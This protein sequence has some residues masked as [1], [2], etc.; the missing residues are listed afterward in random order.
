[1]RSFY[2]Y[3]LIATALAIFHVNAFA[4]QTSCTALPLTFAS[5]DCGSV[6]TTVTGNF[7]A[8]TASGLADP[9]SCGS[10][11]YSSG[12][13]D[14]YVSAIVP[15]GQYA[16]RF[17]MEWSGCG[18]FC[19]SNPGWA[20][21][22]A[23]GG[24]CN[25][26]TP[27]ICGGDDGLVPSTG[28]N[29]SI[30]SLQ[31]GDLVI[32]RVWETDNQDSDID[33]Q[34]MVIPPND[35]CED[36]LPL[37]GYGCN[38][39]ASDL[40]EPDTWAPNQGLF[41]DNCTGG[42][43]SSNENGVWYTFSVDPNTPQ[44]I[45]IQILNV[46]CDNTGAGNMQMGI[47]TNSNTCNLNAETMVECAVGLGN[48]LLGPVNLSVGDYYLFV[49]G[50]AGANCI[51][52]F[53]STEV[54]PIELGRFSGKILKQQTHLDWTTYTESDNDYFEVLHSTNGRDFAPIG[55]VA[56][57]GTTFQLQDYSFIHTSPSFGEN[58]YRLRQVDLDGRYSFSNTIVVSYLKSRIVEVYP[59]PLVG[60]TLHF[61]VEG[62][63]PTQIQFNL[64]DASGKLIFSDVLSYE[65]EPTIQFQ[66]PDLS[67]GTY[68][69]TI[70]LE[71]VGYHNGKIVK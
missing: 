42:D 15:N 20:I 9:G 46:N 28:F 51:W 5:S 71:G 29:V 68:F 17:E 23:N 35:F 13:N 64:T 22:L 66:L 27:I 3:I 34:A 62:F 25:T 16:L 21:Y 38:Y 31:P 44:P 55:E 54:L 67:R 70:D 11:V 65:N 39:L 61:D 14:Y 37:Q 50:N 53:E 12:I 40:N 58:Y 48:V 36:A 8:A 60:Q 69:Y 63:D 56:G 59:N 1:M 52:E 33:I 10:G 4:Q 6:S 2:T 18:L 45:S 32:A 57:H 49:D 7:G 26:L 43:W 24:V 41:D 30:T 47:W 19:V